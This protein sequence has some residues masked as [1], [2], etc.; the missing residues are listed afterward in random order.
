V[1]RLFGGNIGIGGIEEA[2]ELL[3]A[4][5]L[6]ALPL[7][8]AFEE[9]DGSEQRRGAMALVVVCHGSSASFLHRQAGL[10]VVERLNLALLVDREHDDMIRLMPIVLAMAEPVQWVAPAGGPASVNGPHAQRSPIEPRNARR[11]R[12]VAPQ[13]AAPSA[14]NRSCQ[15]QIT[16]LALPVRCMISFVPWPSA[17]SRTILVR[18]TYFC[19][20][21][22]F[23]TAASS[24]ARSAAL[25]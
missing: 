1:D 12:L 8:L 7:D 13:P 22:R 2:D 17:V 24:V 3:M 5:A 25:K 14:P 15:R 19:V 9:V 18:Q 11:A 10:R 16:V 21:F 23:K 4:M 20:L 6:H